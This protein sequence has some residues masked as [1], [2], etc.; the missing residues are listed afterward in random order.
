MFSRI[1]AAETRLN[2]SGDDAARQPLGGPNHGFGISSSK[3][4]ARVQ[5]WG[6][7]GGCPRALLV[8]IWLDNFIQFFKVQ[9]LIFSSAVTSAT[10]RVPRQ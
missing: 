9:T 10:V 7:R 2:P 6:C 5:C 4:C 3:R 8:L 1:D